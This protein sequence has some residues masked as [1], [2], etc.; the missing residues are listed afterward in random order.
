M[1][2]Q[3]PFL[4]IDN[5]FDTAPLGIQC[6]LE[7]QMDV[8]LYVFNVASDTLLLCQMLEQSDNILR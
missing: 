1:S 4:A 7:Y 2:S 8:Y 3:A 6:R 5:C